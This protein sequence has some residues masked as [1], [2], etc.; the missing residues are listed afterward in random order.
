MTDTFL[1]SL[2]TV[3][4][5]ADS[6]SCAR[7]VFSYSSVETFQYILPRSRSSIQATH[8]LSLF[9]YFTQQLIHGSTST[10]IQ[11]CISW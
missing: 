1:Y 4:F 2:L 8:T 7:L 11:T 9:I 3:S 6:S 10:R 5:D